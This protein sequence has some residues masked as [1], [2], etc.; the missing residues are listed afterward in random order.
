MTRRRRRD[1]FGTTRSLSWTATV[2][3]VLFAGLLSAI[4]VL[5][6]REALRTN[7]QQ[8]VTELRSGAVIAASKLTARRAELRARAKRLAQSPRLQAASMSGDRRVL[9]AIARAEGAAISGRGPTIG[10]LP[11]APRLTATVVLGAPDAEAARV[12]L[13]LPLRPVLLAG[14]RRDVP[15]PAGAS[16][17]VANTGRTADPARIAGAAPIEPHEWVVASEPVAAVADRS[18]PYIRRLI[19]AALLTFLVAVFVAARLTRPLAAI[20]EDLSDRAERDPLTGL[21]NR[22]QLDER[23]RE[24]LER[25]GRY[26]THLALVLVDVDDFKRINDRHGHQF[27]D[28]VLQAVA[29]VLST[30]VR[31]LDVAGRFGGEEFAIVLPGTAAPGAARVAEH[32]RRALTELDLTT[33]DGEAVPVTASFGVADFP[34]ASTVEELVAEADGYLYAAKRGGKNQ[35]AG[36]DLVFGVG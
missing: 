18:R 10:G 30:S 16:L 36:A 2:L 12:T 23:L 7:R 29:G 4:V 27:G 3:L 24:E 31:E 15:L 22:R 14:I 20:V 35:V 17:G 11:P 25:A 9:Q 32:V 19:V 21:A 33:P 34:T 1:R 6:N 28:R 13:A 8:A 26:G 5:L